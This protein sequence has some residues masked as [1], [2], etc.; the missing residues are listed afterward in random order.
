[1][2]CDLI[3]EGSDEVQVIQCKRWTEN[4]IV[5][6]KQILYLYGTVTMMQLKEPDK[7]YKGVFITTTTLSQIAQACADKLD[8]KVMK[9][10]YVKEGIV[11]LYG[12]VHD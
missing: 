8:I 1:M 7:K 2:G 10:D 9:I 5:H 3:A 12:H 11:F 4:K 6:E